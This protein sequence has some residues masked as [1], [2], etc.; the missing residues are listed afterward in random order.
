[1]S[2]MLDV[3]A[4]MINSML[5]CLWSRLECAAVVHVTDAK[6]GAVFSKES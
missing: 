6:S 5:S 4:D 1:L 2:A 3:C